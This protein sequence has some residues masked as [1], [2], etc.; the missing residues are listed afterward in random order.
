[1]RIRAK[2]FK[3]WLQANFT[4]DQLKDMATHGANTGWYGLI[5]YSDTTQLYAKYKTELWEYLIEDSESFGC[6]NPF[7]FLATLNGAKDV[8]DAATMENLIVW[9]AAERLSR[10]MTDYFD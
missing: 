2:T 5:Y 3:Q 8:Y 4:K 1:M 6:I 7:E 9:Y 10:E